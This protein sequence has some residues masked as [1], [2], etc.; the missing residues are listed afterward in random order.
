MTFDPIKWHTVISND[1]KQFN[2]EID[3]SLGTIVG[4]TIIL[5]LA[6][7]REIFDKTKDFVGSIYY[8]D[9][10]I[11]LLKDDVRINDISEALGISS[12]EIKNTLKNIIENIASDY[13]LTR[14]TAK[15]ATGIVYYIPKNHNLG[16]YS[17]GPTER[18]KSIYNIYYKPA[19]T[20]IFNIQSENDWVK[21]FVP[22][23]DTYGFPVTVECEQVGSIGNI[24]PQ[25]IDYDFGY[26]IQ[27]NYSRAVNLFSIIGGSDIETDE[28]LIGR[29][30]SKW[31]GVNL[32]TVS[33]YKQLLTQYD[34]RD[35]YVAGPG[36]LFMQRAITGAI[37][38]Y[39]R[40][41]QISTIQTSINIP[42]ANTPIKIKNLL[43]N[44]MYVRNIEP[45]SNN[46]NITVTKDTNPLWKWSTRA[47]DTLTCNQ[48]GAVTVNITYN[49]TIAEIQK[50]LN[51][52]ENK[53][54]GVDVMVREAWSLDFTV[55]CSLTYLSR[56]SSYSVQQN[57]RTALFNYIKKLPLGSKIATSDLINI[58]EDVSGVDTVPSLQIFK[59]GNVVETIQALPIE[60]LNLTE[61]IFI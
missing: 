7:I 2:P 21:Y 53:L 51:L 41:Y 34:V 23:L 1:I 4:D 50:I 31:N 40:D 44:Y 11:N 57:T 29:I 54:L 59:E 46:V 43:E 17:V 12:V 56:Y 18:V 27:G 35:I 39:I 48:D 10:I 15:P 60:F 61:V 26:Y 24:G 52:E 42:S 16:M 28:Q 9:G 49:A 6:I 5:P 13:G 14:L 45:S 36:D 38:I 32:G 37:D 8:L 55:K 47:N 20:F 33:G 3:T 30:K 22:E 25:Q 58:V 19:T